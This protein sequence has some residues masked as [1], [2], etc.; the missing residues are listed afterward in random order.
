MRVRLR[1]ICEDAISSKLIA[2]AGAGEFSHCGALMDD[3]S[4]LGARH[5]RIGDIPAGVQIRPGNYAK[6][7]KCAIF[8]FAATPEQE[9]TFWDFNIAQIGKPYDMSAIYGFIT[10]RNWRNP[11]A[12]IC[13]EQQTV[14]CETAE[15]IAPLYLASFKVSPCTLAAVVSG[16]GAKR[17]PDS[18][19]G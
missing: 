12:W 14:A 2:L 5:D 6:F 10:G 17:I 4:E 16:A 19:G 15:L 7:T 9:R 13:S 11:D 3:G 8:E 1:F 18:S